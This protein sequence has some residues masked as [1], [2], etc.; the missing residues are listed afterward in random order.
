MA[1]AATKR[2]A[3]SSADG[4]VHDE[5]LGGDAA[6]PA[7]TARAATATRRPVDLAEG[8]TMKGSLPPSSRTDFL[9]SH[10]A[11]AATGA[12]ADSLPVTW[13]AAM[14][15]SAST[16]AT[17]SGP[18]EQRLE[19]PAGKTGAAEADLNGERALRHVGGVLE[20]AALPA[21]RAAEKAEDLPEGEVPGHDGEDDA[22]RSPAEGGV[23]R[24]CVDG[25]RR[26][27]AGGVFGVEAAGGGALGDFGAGLAMGLP[28][29]EVMSA[30]RSAVSPSRR[31]ASLF[32]QSARWASGS[33]AARENAVS[34]SAIFSSRASSVSG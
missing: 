17:C 9:M 34:A 26:E 18:D 19:A 5:A 13:T 15:A 20:Q 2:D 25:F 1:S 24:R 14:R 28:I 22:E 12:A 31:R 21:I 4:F 30:A 16:T 32:M 7:L 29:S 10:P 23:E 3:N 6:L 8:M 11:R 27:D 33:S